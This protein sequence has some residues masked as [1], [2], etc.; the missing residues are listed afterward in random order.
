M[1]AYSIKPPLWTRC[2]VRPPPLPS[3]HP[4]PWQQPEPNRVARGKRAGD[5]TGRELTVIGEHDTVSTASYLNI[6][7]EHNPLQADALDASR[8]AL[9]ATG[10]R[11][12]RDS[13]PRDPCGPYGFQDRPRPRRK[14]NHRIGFAIHQRTRCPSPAPRISP[15]CP[16]SWPNLWPPGRR[17]PMQSRPG[18]SRWC[19]PR[20]TVTGD[21]PM[22]ARSLG[23][24]RLNAKRTA[25]A[26][27]PTIDSFP[28]SLDRN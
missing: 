8:R 18:Y 11:R 12:G 14:P 5:G 28:A 23:V 1:S 3:L 27:S 25:Q 20:A 7:M 26:T 6:S 16:P 4:L 21:D 10:E 17:C 9:T 19:E 2:P 13:N 24:E 22:K 15:D